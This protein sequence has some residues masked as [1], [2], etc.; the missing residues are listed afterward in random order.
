MTDITP[1]TGKALVT[2]KTLWVN[3]LSI[4]GMV[5]SAM[6]GYTIPA[7]WSVSILAVI[8]IVIR[9]VTKEAVVW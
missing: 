5:A 7:E 6:F 2:S 1:T 8:N 9:L 4:A 3:L